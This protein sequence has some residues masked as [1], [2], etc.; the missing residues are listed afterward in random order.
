M[1]KLLRTT[2]ASTRVAERSA[3]ILRS[4]HHLGLQNRRVRPGEKRNMQRLALNKRHHPLRFLTSAK[5]VFMQKLLRRVDVQ[6][7]KIPAATSVQRR[8]ENCADLLWLQPTNMRQRKRQE[9][10]DQLRVRY[11]NIPGDRVRRRARRVP[12]SLILRCSYKSAT[13]PQQCR[14]DQSSLHL[15]SM[16]PPRE[17]QQPTWHGKNLTCASKVGNHNPNPATNN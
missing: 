17:H 13:Q 4:H 9:V 8:I 14:Q 5:R 1:R 10:D 6:P 7:V 12:S 11:S 2:H 16:T 3:K 15:S